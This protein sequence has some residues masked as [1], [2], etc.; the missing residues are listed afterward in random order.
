MKIVK[1]DSIACTSCILMNEIFNEI[2]EK[3]NFKL[4]EYDFDEDY[5]LISKYN[6]KTLPTFIFYEN[7]SEVNR[8]VGENDIDKFKE[9][10]KGCEKN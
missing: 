6:I 7:D 8:L 3:Y 2:K 10:L 9:I 1:I 5:D 4:E